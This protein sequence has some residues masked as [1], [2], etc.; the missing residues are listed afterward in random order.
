MGRTDSTRDVRD[1]LTRDHH[2]IAQAAEPSADAPIEIRLAQAEDAE[3]LAHC[4]YRAYGDSY[5]H[6]WAYQPDALRQRWCERVTVSVVGLAADGEVVGHLAA[7]FERPESRVAEAGQAVVDP[8]Y[9]G[10]HLFESM[11]TFL[12]D[13]AGRDGLYGL[14]SEATAV[15][16]YSQRG[17]LALGAHEM[18]FLVGY[19]PSGVDYKG[20]ADGAVPHRETAALMY[21]R[22]SP[23]P[24]RVVHPP[25][26]Y[27]DISM[28][29][30]GNAGLARTT[31]AGE[32]WSSSKVSQ[33]DLHRDPGHNA[34][35]LQCKAAGADIHAA[36]VTHLE[37]LKTDGVDCVYLDLP[38]ADPNVFVHGADLDGLGFG[39]GCILPEIRDEGDVLRLQH[40]NGV[41]PHIEEIATASDFGRSLLAEIVAGLEA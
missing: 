26:A 2:A 22:T 18:G 28:R 23:E 27:R 40:L 31:G 30:Y 41:A 32:G 3:S 14:F 16:P 4:F 20:I 19:I 11:K 33:V 8:R 36:I 10:H 17:N 38:M 21:L 25:A 5:D 6:A 15:H 13:W 34:A 39:F 12:A 37:A 7:N 35:Q 29:V 9:R 1:K 24:A